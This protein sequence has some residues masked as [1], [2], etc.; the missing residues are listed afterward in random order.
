MGTSE[1]LYTASVEEAAEIGGEV[2][3]AAPGPVLLLPR[4]ASDVPLTF[5][6][7]A[8]KVATCM[9]MSTKYF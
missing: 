3:I 7:S 4:G 8:N 5:S 2:R 9:V 1:A 6:S